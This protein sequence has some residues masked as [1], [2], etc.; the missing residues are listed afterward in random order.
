MCRITYNF[1]LI[2]QGQIFS[3]M[4]PKEL[5]KVNIVTVARLSCQVERLL[6]VMATC[7]QVWNTVLLYY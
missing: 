6:N 7:D 3:I 5:K 1:V 2:K 4:V